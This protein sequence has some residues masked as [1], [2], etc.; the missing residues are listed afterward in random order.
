MKKMISDLRH[1]FK[2]DLVIF[3]FLFSEML[4]MDFWMGLNGLNGD[5]CWKSKLIFPLV[6]LLNKTHGNYAFDHNCS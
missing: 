3:I 5:Y 4:E 6:N 1:S 2:S